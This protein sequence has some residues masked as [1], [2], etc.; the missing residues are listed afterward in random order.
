MSWD[1]VFGRLLTLVLVGHVG[2]ILWNLR[3]VVR[4]KPRDL[5]PEPRVSILVPARNEEGEIG[6]CLRSLLHQT[7]GDVEIV[8]LDDRSTDR[9]AAIVRAVGGDR[10]RLIGGEELPE[11]WTGKNWA[12]H[13]LAQA[14]TGDVLCF[15]DAD[16]HLAPDA[17]AS[18]VSTLVTHDV[19]LVAVM[20]RSDSDGIA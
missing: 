11:G 15:V 18:V 16:T 13:Q 7:H 10:V 8:V 1:F 4:P 2:L 19:G 5:D 6:D 20:L 14:A 3:V 17:V 12:C 9:T